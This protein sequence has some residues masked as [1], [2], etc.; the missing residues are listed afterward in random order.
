MTN[1]VKELSQSLLARAEARSIRI[2]KTAYPVWMVLDM[3]ALIDDVIAIE[4]RVP[5]AKQKCP[6]GATLW[7]STRAFADF[8][9][10]RDEEYSLSQRK[11]ILE[12]GC[13]VG[14]GSCILAQ[15]G[16]SHVIATDVEPEFDF[17]VERNATVFGVEGRVEFRYL[18]WGE[19]P[20]GDLAQQC[21]FILACD[22]L[23]EPEH[24]KLLP[25]I[26]RDLLSDE[27]VF[28]LGDPKRFCY[29]S[30]VEELNRCFFDVNV[31]SLKV[32]NEDVDL[33]Q[34][35]VNKE[36]DFTEV[37]FLECRKPKRSR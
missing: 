14:V 28:V 13:G 11:R 15:Y 19:D 29:L 25:R 18:N 16:A 6:Y 34:G 17:L 23:Y 7:P 37:Q 3:D 20:P 30:A 2:G 27:G 21:D 12:L 32:E 8:I 22:V 26:A 9:Q 36:T 33:R 24:I 5:A 1:K 31:T 35:V 4:D 10:L